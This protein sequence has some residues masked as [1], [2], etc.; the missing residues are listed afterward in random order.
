[1]KDIYPGEKSGAPTF[2]TPFGDYLYFQVVAAN[3]ARWGGGSGAES[4]LDRFRRYFLHRY[5]A[6]SIA[7]Q[8]Q[9]DEF[10]PGRITDQFY[11]TATARQTLQANSP[12]SP[13][14]LIIAVILAFNTPN[15]RVAKA[16]I[17]Y[18]PLLFPLFYEK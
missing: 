9:S 1:M 18:T 6:S 12:A 15:S 8:V 7:F 2:F 11:A 14:N 16:R 10:R 4:L 5:R 3:M 17:A 13:L